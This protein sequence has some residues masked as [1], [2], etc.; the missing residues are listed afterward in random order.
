MNEEKFKRS[1]G[2][3][4]APASAGIRRETYWE[5]LFSLQQIKSVAARS[6]TV[7]H[8][9]AGGV[10]GLG[11]DL[12]QSR[13]VPVGQQLRPDLVETAAG[14]GLVVAVGGLLDV[15]VVPRRLRVVR[16][17]DH[18]R[19]QV[20]RVGGTVQH[21][22]DQ[23]HRLGTGDVRVGAEGPVGITVDPPR[24][25]RAVD[26][27]RGP[28]AGDVREPVAAGVISAEEAGGDGGELRAGDVVVG[29][30]ASIGI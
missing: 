8:L 3:S 27:L 13:P 16:P 5:A 24:G 9:A 22:V 19:Q 6:Q 12:L 20:A 28:V 18:V 7:G 4:S 2:G 21:P 29:P 23:G 15:G 26:I 30:E 14:P 17:A 10:V 11:P 1:R 25:R